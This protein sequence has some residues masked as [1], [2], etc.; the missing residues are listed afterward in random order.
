LNDMG[1]F[2]SLGNIIGI[3]SFTHKRK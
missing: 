3:Y 1:V 2:E